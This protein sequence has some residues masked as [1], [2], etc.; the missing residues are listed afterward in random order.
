[1]PMK[2]K[3]DCSDETLM[4][5]FRKKLD[6]R[7]FRILAERHYP[8]AVRFAEQ[9]LGDNAAAYDAVQE[10]FIR[11]VRYRKRYDPRKP[12]LPWFYSI[13]RNICIDLSRKESRYFDMLKR[14]TSEQLADTGKDKSL[15][16]RAN[17][18]IACLGEK[19]AQIMR[20][21]YI[22]GMSLAEIGVKMGCSTEAAKKR[23]QRLIARIREKPEIQARMSENCPL[24][25]V[26]ERIK[27][28]R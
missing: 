4:Q 13:L 3:E 18:V 23:L 8:R 5:E 17:G 26:D 27:Y 25:N 7:V 21:R 11:V 6:D 16:E 9:R 28:V 1:M 12:F 20:M 22:N 2:S 10:A 15:R 19:D 24:P 14:F